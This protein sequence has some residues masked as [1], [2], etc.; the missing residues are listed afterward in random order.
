MLIISSRGIDLECLMFFSFFLSR[1]GSLRALMTRE[2]AEGTTETAACRFWIVSL[3]VTRRPFYLAVSRMYWSK[4]P[5]S[6]RTQS[7]V[8]FAISSPTFFGERPRGPILGARAD[9][10]PTS[11][12]VA[13]RVLQNAISAHVHAKRELEIYRAI[14]YISLT[15][16]GSNFGAG[17]SHV[18]RKLQ[19][20]Q[21]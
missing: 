20:F 9:E 7:P 8:A 17:F 21:R 6:I 15:S 16:L 4:C 12:P 18:S 14:T 11:P 5:H 10:A 13:L 2:D 1:G 3:T 19:I